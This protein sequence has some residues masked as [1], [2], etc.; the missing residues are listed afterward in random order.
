ML[1]KIYSNNIPIIGSPLAGGFY[2]GRFRIGRIRFALIVS[3]N[4]NG[5][6][7]GIWGK[8]GKDINGANSPFDGMSNTKSMAD[9]GSEIAKWVLGLTINGYSD[10]Y[11]PSRDELEILYRNLK[12]GRCPNRCAFRDGDNPSSMPP[13][14][15]YTYQSPEQTKAESFR[16]GQSEAFKSNWYWS[17]TQYSELSAWA[18]FLPDGYQ[19]WT[20]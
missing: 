18:H 16:D 12:P 3:P 2:A 11:L 6:T 19:P 8:F 7:F 15:P 13:G 20:P 17:S 5:E 14:F 10:W 4:A 1:E 9:S